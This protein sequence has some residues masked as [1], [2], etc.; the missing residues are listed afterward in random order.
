MNPSLP[1]T[2]F[3]PVITKKLIAPNIVW[4]NREHFSEELVRENAFCIPQDYELHDIY[5]SEERIQ[6]ADIYGGVGLG[7]AGGSGRCAA[8]GKI[9][10][11]GVGRTKLVTPE[12]DP[13]HTSGTMALNEAVREVIWSEILAVA[14]PY[15]AVKSYAIVLT[16][17]VFHR[18]HEFKQPIRQRALLFREFVVRPAHYLRSMRFRLPNVEDG[19][20][21]EASV[22]R[23]A[24]NTIETTFGE[25]FD[26]KTS[27]TDEIDLVNTGLYLIAQRF[28]A[29]I[30]T[31]FAKRIFHGGLSCSNIA[32]DGS[33]LDFGTIGSVEKYRRETLGAGVLDQWRHGRELLSTLEDLHFHIRKYFL[34]DTSK[35][36]TVSELNAEFTKTLEIRKEISMLTMAGIPE[37]FIG[38]YDFKSRQRFY[39]CLCKIYK[40]GANEIYTFSPP[41]A[42]TASS[43]PTKASLGCFDL[44]I[45]FTIAACTLDADLDRC[46]EAELDDSILRAE[47]VQL[48]GDFRRFFLQQF[49]INQQIYAHIYLAIQAMRINADIRFLARGNTVGTT[50]GTLN[51]ESCI[52]EANPNGVGLFI[53]ST[54]RRGR[55]IL[56]DL[57]PDLE[58]SNPLEQIANLEVMGGRL[59]DFVIQCINVS[60]A[61]QFVSAQLTKLLEHVS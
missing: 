54:I 39:R 57:H 47:F 20:S 51:K 55:Y 56:H 10:I 45:I 53:D 37:Q 21:G 58:G 40:R 31:A 32:L 24:I 27:K 4:V 50:P 1:N 41:S 25:L 6:F 7:H 30:G 13:N 48:Y 52:Y 28:A 43:Y 16:N 2:S 8:H 5:S 36:I 3:V 17:G 26:I 11:K 23:A 9:Q 12:E 35:L 14:L 60:K 22:K 34:K 38:S 18:E 49:S 61:A 15:G 42:D 19:W 29:Q 59:H 33:F 44:N 46:L